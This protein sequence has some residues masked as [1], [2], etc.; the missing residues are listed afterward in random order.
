MRKT[1]LIIGMVLALGAFALAQNQA[2]QQEQDGS[3][4][5]DMKRAGHNMKNAAK[6]TGHA[7]K[8]GAVAT[9]KPGADVA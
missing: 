5:Q 9:A 1:T 4:K 6:D 8:K 2:Q 7:V 3:A